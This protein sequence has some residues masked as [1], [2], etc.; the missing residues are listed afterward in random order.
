MSFFFFQYVDYL[1]KL[2]V[3]K[4]HC[5]IKLYFCDFFILEAR[6]MA[7]TGGFN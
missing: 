5:G 3:N 7:G 4:D 2:I 1:M 6:P